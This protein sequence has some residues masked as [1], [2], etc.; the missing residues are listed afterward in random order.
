MRKVLIVQVAF[1]VFCLF[2]LAFLLYA[3]MM[4]AVSHGG[5]LNLASIPPATP[6]ITYVIGMWEI[7]FGSRVLAWA[8]VKVRRIT[9]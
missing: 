9:R 1:S 5:N 4:A 3:G 2:Q 8:W 6:I 7:L